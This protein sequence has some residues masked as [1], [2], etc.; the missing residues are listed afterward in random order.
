MRRGIVA[1][2]RV[3]PKS[4]SIA[5]MDSVSTAIDA[6]SFT[7]PGMA[8]GE[9]SSDRTIIVIVTHRSAATPS[10]TVGGHAVTIDAVRAN[11]GVCIGRVTLPQGTSADVV[12]NFGGSNCP[13]VSVGLFRVV[14][15][16]I[17]VA[18]S[19]AVFNYGGT[20]LNNIPAPPGS[21]GVAAYCV[22]T[23]WGSGVIEPYHYTPD[24][25]SQSGGIVAGTGTVQTIGRGSVGVVIYK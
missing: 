8:V 4:L 17:E 3:S 22:C 7:F 19:Q 24:G 14:G 5:F 21:V 16:P 6:R 12:L 10:I 11:D 25:V 18:Y 13:N 2:A 1:S 23:S 15:G 20:T 9:A